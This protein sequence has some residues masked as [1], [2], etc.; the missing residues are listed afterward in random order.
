MN[1]N[2]LHAIELWE[3]LSE[4]TKERISWNVFKDIGPRVES[5]LDIYGFTQQGHAQFWV[6]FG[7]QLVRRFSN[8]EVLLAFEDALAEERHDPDAN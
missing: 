5:V 4:L 7:K 1:T 8:S 6:W 3:P 2:P